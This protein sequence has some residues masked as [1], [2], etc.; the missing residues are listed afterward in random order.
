[1]YKAPSE[2]L[3]MA[4][5]MVMMGSCMVMPV[6]NTDLNKAQVARESLV[7]RQRLSVWPRLLHNM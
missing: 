5:Q 1:M 4:G 7:A 6:A 2:E 3:W